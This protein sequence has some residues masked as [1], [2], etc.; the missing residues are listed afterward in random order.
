MPLIQTIKKFPNIRKGMPFEFSFLYEFVVNSEEKTPTRAAVRNVLMSEYYNLGIK[1]IGRG[2]YSPKELSN[3]FLESLALDDNSIVIDWGKT[4]RKKY[5]YNTQLYMKREIMMLGT[6]PEYI[7]N[8]LSKY[9]KIKYTLIKSKLPENFEK[10]IFE[11]SKV[12]EY[13]ELKLTIKELKKII[14]VRN[15][16]DDNTFK[17]TDKYIENIEEIIENE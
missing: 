16:F 10:K 14:K 3:E 13:F 11:K 7:V 9:E 8:I 4:L 15:L 17:K 12:I 2:L 5:I 1:N 6:F